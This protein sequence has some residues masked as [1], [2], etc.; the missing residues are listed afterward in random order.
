MNLGIRDKSLN[1]MT[2]S[3]LWYRKGEGVYTDM[4]LNV[5]HSNLSNNM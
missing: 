5:I 1:L 2:G 3:I 4:L